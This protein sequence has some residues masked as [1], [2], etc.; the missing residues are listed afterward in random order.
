M[1]GQRL[2][3]LTN[4]LNE[5][6]D[7]NRI[8]KPAAAVILCLALSPAQAFAASWTL[9]TNQP[10]VQLYQFKL[11]TDGTV[12]AESGNVQ[13]WLKLTP[14]SSGSFI[15]GTW[16]S[17]A[18]T[19]TKRG[20][21]AS[22]I[23][24]SGKV[25]VLGGENYGP[26]DDYVWSATG[27]IYD[28]VAN[29]WTP[30]TNF[31]A[32]SCFQVTYHVSGNT[33]SG[34]NIISGLPSAVTPT[35]LPGWTVTGSGVPANATITSVDSSTQVHISANATATQTNVA[36]AFTG[37]PASCY[38]DVPTMLLSSNLILTGSLVSPASYIY[39]ISTDSWSFA[40]NKVYN[41]S[42]DEEGWTRLADGRILTYDIGQT[43]RTNQGYAEIY[44]PSTNTWSSIS[45][46][47]GTANG[48]LPNLV[49]PANSEVGPSVRLQDG[50]VFLTGSSGH[51]ALYN[52]S[53]NTWTAG[54]DI[55]GSLNSQPVLFGT[56]DAPGAVMPN[57]H[58]IFAADSGPSPVISNGHTTAG[59]NIITGLS[60]TT[61]IQ[62]GWPVTQ[63]SGTSVIPGGASVT[64]VDSPSQVH[65]S[66]NA[67]GTA[68]VGLQFGGAYA[69]PTQLFDFNPAANTISAVSPG[70]NDANLARDPSYNNSM[71]IL[72]NGQLLFSD[73]LGQ[74]WI[75]TADGTASPTYLPVI[76][77]VS[78]NG[79]GVFTLTGKQLS[80]QN[81]GAAYGDDAEMDENY[82][83]VRLVNS[84]GKTFYCKTTNWSSV[85]VG[86]GSTPETVN[87]TLHP[88]VTAGNYVLIVSAAGISSFPLAINISKAE[89][90]A[91]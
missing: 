42:S 67:T 16:S 61:I 24:P 54:P 12:M 86:T 57:G 11:L 90:S 15:N 89:V 38:G 3:F 65:I 47:D 69:A 77:N 49:N 55:M 21:F 9:L 76:N 59:S 8:L 23:L 10:P 82:P 85:G 73:G 34:S 30:I 66:Q 40:A 27:A 62:V 33:V 91:Q 41:D 56:D 60:S 50:R 39:N 17:L 35:F 88:N 32:Q 79:A 87:F 81:A 36:L 7:T 78:Y 14:D 45:P 6:F 74:I 28:P 22:E 1:K 68:T 53:T 29:T 25:W 20:S 72:P 2:G 19:P 83:V 18:S 58:V 75:Y 43:N 5:P 84:S 37:T 26:G 48:T 71:L 31:P 46:A 80:G 44:N 52:P 4:L 63:T 70:L 64:S 51:T 13:D